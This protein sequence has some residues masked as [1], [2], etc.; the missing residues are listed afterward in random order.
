MEFP[1]RPPGRGSGGDLPDHEPGHLGMEGLDVL[2]VDAIVPDMGVGHDDNLAAAGGIGEDFL[3]SAQGG[4]EDH[5][6]K[7]LSASSEPFAFKEG[8][9]LECEDGAGPLLD[10]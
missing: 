3:V 2:S 1:R 8:A 4:V 9:V 6:T 5:L 10:R 7:C